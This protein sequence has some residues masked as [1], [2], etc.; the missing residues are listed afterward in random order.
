MRTLAKIP[1]RYDS[2]SAARSPQPVELK[3]GQL[4]V[5]L[6]RSSVILCDSVVYSSTVISTE[7]WCFDVT[8]ACQ[9]CGVQRDVSLIL[10]YS[11]EIGLSHVQRQH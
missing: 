3:S 1:G 7:K 5:G 6:K 11:I 2:W 4:E 10:S 9:S 8:I